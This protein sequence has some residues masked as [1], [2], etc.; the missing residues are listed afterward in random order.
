MKVP[1]SLIIAAMLLT[2]GCGKGAGESAV[3]AIP[4]APGPCS[5]PTNGS[6]QDISVVNHK[7]VLNDQC[8]GT[9][10]YCNEV[11]TAHVQPSGNVILLTTATNG[12]PECMP[13]GATTCTASYAAHVGIGP[14]QYVDQL[15]IQC[16]AGLKISTVY[17]RL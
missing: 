8:G 12:G 11:F 1:L 15:Q 9:T 5:D 6:W 17:N 13:I 16:G 10:T 3:K 7:L 14:N 2:A 4:K